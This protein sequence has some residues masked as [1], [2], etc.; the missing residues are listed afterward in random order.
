ML[1]IWARSAL[2]GPAEC[3]HLPLFLVLANC[4]IY[5]QAGE[6]EEYRKLLVLEGDESNKV[7]PATSNYS[8]KV[9]QYPKHGVFFGI[10]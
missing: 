2:S 7:G 9:W 4:Y 1:S 3:E 5:A 6:M 8:P 10:C